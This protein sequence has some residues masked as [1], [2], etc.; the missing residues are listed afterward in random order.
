MA[1][2]R[3]LSFFCVWGEV[4]FEGGGGQKKGKFDKGGIKFGRNM[5]REEGITNSSREDTFFDNPN[6]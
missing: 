6:V 2:L 4:N 5:V 1:T 3:D